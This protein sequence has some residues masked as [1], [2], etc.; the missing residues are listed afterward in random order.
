MTSV[1][2]DLSGR[3][4]GVSSRFDDVNRRFDDLQFWLQT[5][6]GAVVVIGGLVAQWLL[7]WKGL[8]GGRH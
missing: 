8:E 5:F 6:F 2:T 1:R 3:F 4:D 7:M